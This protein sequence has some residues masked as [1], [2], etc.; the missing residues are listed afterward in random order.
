MKI[1][2]L[3][4]IL[5]ISFLS[6][7]ASLARTS[8]DNHTGFWASLNPTTKASFHVGVE[9]SGKLAPEKTTHIFIVGSAMGDES[10]QFFQSALLKA[11]IYEK[12]Y[13][14]HQVIIIS[15]PDV[16]KTVSNREVFNRYQV[17]IVA[18]EEGQLTQKQLYRVL[19]KF[20]KI[21]SIDFYGH[22]TPWALRL[23]RG[24]AIL[25]AHS[26][27]EKLRGHFTNGAYATL[28]G[29]N[30]GFT[31]APKLSELWGIPVSGALTGSVFERIQADGKWYKKIDRSS[32]E[33]VSE[34]IVN[35]DSRISCAKGVCWRLKAQRHDYASYWGHFKSGGLSFFKFFCRFDDKE[36]CLK[37]MALNL[38]SSPS[39]NRIQAKPS[40]EKFQEKIFDQLCSTA[41]DSNYFDK[42]KEGILAAVE[43]GD[44][45]FQ[46][47]PGNAL[48]CN[49]RGCKAEVKC[50]RERIGNEVR[51]GSCSL[52]TKKNNNPTTLVREYLA[53]KDGF[54][55]LFIE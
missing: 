34:N 35:F 37:A 31:L 4:F 30:G 49:F 33:Y 7:N 8:N 1:N 29:C 53:Y 52:A 11:K 14:E 22:S 39:I 5:S 6:L 12:L 45:I 15:Q 54:K 41:K 38:L 55:L 20:K 46:M 50:Q 21:A 32:S 3:S 24:S 23:G 16:I 40:W 43:R 17:K 47:H 10:D 13:P 44:N 9:T 26:D 27:W 42:C 19:V 18:S 25:T 48:D 36:K 2:L 51:P 28:N